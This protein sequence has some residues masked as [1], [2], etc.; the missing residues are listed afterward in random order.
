MAWLAVGV[1]S[2]IAGVVQTVTGFG[3]VVVLMMAL[4]FFFDMIDAPAL[5]IVINQVFC[6][7]L[8]GKYWRHTRWGVALVPT[9][10]Y[11]AA[12][13][14]T[15]RLATA[16]PTRALVIA[17][18]VFLMCLSVYFLAVAARIRLKPHRW[19]GA[20]CGALSGASAGLFAIGGPPM[21]LYFINACDTH[22]EYLACMQFLFSVTGAVS[23][24]GRIANG[25]LH[26]AILPYGA[27]GTVGIL[28]GIRLGEK[29][30]GKLDA[31]RARTVV[32]AFV[33]VSGLILLLQNAL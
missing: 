25:V 6:M 13:L 31:A 8:Y 9:V 4:P 18:G 23:L 17:L 20:A 16:V 2:V 24:I 32:Y 10:L 26:P 33:G 11:S 3:S 22:L 7:V 21:A 1:M 5:A 28:A 14:V 15:I 12:S 29:I 30:N 19:V 27:L